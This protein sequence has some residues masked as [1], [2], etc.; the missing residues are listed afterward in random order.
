MLSPD[1]ES[2]LN[3]L[4]QFPCESKIGL[5]LLA[6]MI[7]WLPIAIFLGQKFK[8]RPFQP[9]TPAQKIPLL[10]PLY[11]L[12][13]FLTWL[14]LIIESTSL[15][16]YGLSFRPKLLISIG[17]GML[18]GL[19]GLG[20]VFG[21]ESKLGWLTWHRDNLSR[22]KTFLLP[23]LGLAL[24]IGLT[25]EFVFRGIFQNILEQD[26]HQWIAAIF[27]S[28]IF[29]LLHLLWERKDTLPQLPG[30]WLMGMV[31]VGARMVDGESLGLAIGLHAGWIWG[32]S[33]LDA[34]E[35]IS[36][37]DEGINW[38]V[39]ISKQPLAGVAGIVCLLGTGL[40]LW[41]FPR[42]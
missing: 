36:Y 32:L 10:V 14:T 23:I 19:G 29:T 35:L 18:L 21:I 6:W 13:P 42:F 34:A 4:G 11:L 40:I 3:W 22:L 31:L 33:T 30:L 5:F 20:V 17:L 26:Y 24:W 2:L 37:T 1:F 28:S 7:L 27:S 25:E 8:W 38:V 16:D 41:Q 9:L 39:G 15:A 12:V